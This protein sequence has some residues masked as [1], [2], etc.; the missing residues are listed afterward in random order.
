VGSEAGPFTDPDGFVC[1]AASLNS[2]LDP[3][4]GLAIAG[5]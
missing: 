3:T 4:L 2:R 5:S 1:E